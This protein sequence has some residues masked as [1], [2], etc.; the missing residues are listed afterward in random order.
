[1]DREIR[2]QERHQQSEAKRH[3]DAAITAELQKQA[4]QVHTQLSQ[5]HKHIPGSPRELSGKSSESRSGRSNS[6][7]KDRSEKIETLATTATPS[8]SSTVHYKLDF[9]VVEKSVIF[10]SFLIFQEQKSQ[11]APSSNTPNTSSGTVPVAALATVAPIL[12]F[13][14]TT[15]RDDSTESDQSLIG[16][17]A[18]PEVIQRYL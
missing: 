13:G 3:R 9:V 6:D 10:N 2:A 8:T 11:T 5:L 14:V 12:P 7:Q 16:P 17:Q 15:L 4:V 1:M 18:H